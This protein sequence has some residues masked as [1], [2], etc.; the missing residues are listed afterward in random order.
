MANSCPGGHGDCPEPAKCSQW[1]ATV[2]HHEAMRASLPA[3]DRGSYEMPGDE[4]P[5]GHC[6]VALED[7]TVCRPMTITVL[8]GSVALTHQNSALGG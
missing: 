4:C 3:G 5:G 7:C 2:A 6:H 8:A 1:K